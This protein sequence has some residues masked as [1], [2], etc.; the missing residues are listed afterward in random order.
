LPKCSRTSWDQC[1]SWQ[2]KVVE[3][4]QEWFSLFCV[5]FVEKLVILVWLIVIGDLWTFLVIEIEI[6]LL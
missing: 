1:S 2:M 4:V 6:I 3:S 5:S